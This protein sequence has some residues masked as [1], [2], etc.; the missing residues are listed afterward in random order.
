MARQK[1]LIVGDNGK[2]IAPTAP[3]T[4]APSPAAAAAMPTKTVTVTVSTPTAE[5][6][7]QEVPISLQ[8][9]QNGAGGEGVGCPI[10]SSIVRQKGQQ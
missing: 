1:T 3:A 2:Q 9:A 4:T 5:G 6:A 10:Q 7:P 8:E